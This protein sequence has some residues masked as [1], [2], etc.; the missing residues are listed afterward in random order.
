M[1]N[2]RMFAKSIVQSARFLR[3]PQST[4]LLY[5]DLGMAADDEGFVEAFTVLRMTDGSMEDLELLQQTDFVRVCNDDLVALIADWKT[6]NHIRQDRIRRSIYRHL[7]E[8][9]APL[10]AGQMPVKCQADARQMSAQ[11]SIDKDNQYKGGE[12]NRAN[13][14]RLHRVPRFI[15]PTVDEVAAYCRKLGSTI[16]PQRFV[17]YYSSTGWKIGSHQMEDWKAAVRTWESRE[18]GKKQIGRKSQ[19]TVIREKS[20]NIR[21]S[22]LELLANEKDGQ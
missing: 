5:Y 10:N 18:Q 7:L 3:L 1:A 11:D 4:R 20:E 17:D 13:T 14:D 2:C 6:N 21:N 12:N 9:A 16:D 15:P 8:E 22:Y 19:E